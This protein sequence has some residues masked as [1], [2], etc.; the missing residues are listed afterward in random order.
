MKVPID[1]ACSDA[2]L[3]STNACEGLDGLSSKDL[4]CVRR[5][6]DATARLDAMDSCHCIAD[7][8]PADDL[9]DYFMNCQF[10][11]RFP[12]PL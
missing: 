2:G 3:E 9:K 6:N 4:G 8:G 5:E 11:R 12:P 7:P 1:C 10:L